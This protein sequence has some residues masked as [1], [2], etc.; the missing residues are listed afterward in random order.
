M[1]NA[2]RKGSQW[3]RDL[4]KELNKLFETTTWKRIAMSGAM[5]TIMNEPLLKADVVGTFD[6]LDRRFVGECKVG[7]GGA[8]MQVSKEWF[9]KIKQ[10]ASECYA[11]PVVFLKF[12]GARSGVQHVV[13]FDMDTFVILMKEVEAMYDEILKLREQ[14]D[15]GPVV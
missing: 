15:K 3:E 8:M 5:G 4:A 7:Y 13:A 1:V 11:L 9:D 2:K 14:H 10:T 12:S 6:F